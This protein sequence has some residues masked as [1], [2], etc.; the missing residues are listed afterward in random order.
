MAKG[1][2][3][4]EETEREGESPSHK[5]RRQVKEQAREYIGTLDEASLEDLEDREFENYEPIRPKR[6]R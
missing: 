6:S 1:R 2:D 4:V 5:K 3:N